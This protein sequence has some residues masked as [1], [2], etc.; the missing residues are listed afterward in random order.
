MISFFR[1]SVCGNLVMKIIES[2][3][4]MVCCG[5]EMKLLEPNTS[6]GD[7][8]KHVPFVSISEH[9]RGGCCDRIV[10][11]KIGEVAHPMEDMHYIQ[12]IVLHT[13]KG[14]H[15]VKLN[16]GDIAE[17]CFCLEVGE[18]VIDAYAYCNRHGLWKTKTE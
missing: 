13:S 15:E 6:D 12:W 10:C 16:P 5:R 18:E 8:E 17:A 7:G 4:P 3:A 9:G 11:V 1:C 14:I 2:G